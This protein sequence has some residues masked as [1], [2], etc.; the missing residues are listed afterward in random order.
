MSGIST[1]DSLFHNR[2]AVLATMHRKEQVIAPIIEPQLGLNILVADK[3]D[4]DKFGT[5]TRDIARNGTQIEAARLKAAAALEITGA[6]IAIASE[7]SF[8]PHPV[9]PYLPSNRELIVFI[10]KQHDLEIVGESFTTETNYHHLVV[11]SYPQALKFAQKIG[12]PHHALIVMSQETQGNQIIKG[13]TT[14]AELEIA[15]N[16]ILASTAKAHIETDMRAMYNPTRMK[17]IAR[18]TQD[19]VTKIKSCCPKCS[20]PGFAITERIAGLPCA[21]CHTPTH[22]T[23]ATVY[24]CQKCGFTQEKLYPNGEEYADPGQCMYCNP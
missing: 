24:E 4:T 6:T 8:T 10:D 2:V 1:G 11:E 22:L 15:V 18:A 16:S 23:L 3:L 9:I 12:F 20:T 13:I 7:G 14:E 5:F 21:A 19:L 17:N